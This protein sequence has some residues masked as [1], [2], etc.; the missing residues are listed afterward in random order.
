MLKPFVAAALALGAVTGAAA[1]EVV[2]LSAGAVK[3]AFTAAAAD[4]QKSSGNTVSAAFAPA[5]ELRKKVAAGDAD[6]IVPAELRRAATS[7]VP[8]TAAPGGRGRC[9]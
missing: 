7:G 2:V 6:I 4:W 9:G 8:S 3:T 5:G 1:A